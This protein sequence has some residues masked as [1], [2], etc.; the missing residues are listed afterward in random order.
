MVGANNQNMNFQIAL[1][2]ILNASD[3][4]QSLLD[5]AR[6]ANM[7]FEDIKNAA[8]LLVNC[9]LLKEKSEQVARP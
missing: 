7:K 9:G 4:S 6:K 8:D 2:W 5:I 3:G 1:L